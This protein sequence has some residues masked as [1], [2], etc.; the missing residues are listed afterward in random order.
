VT[1]ARAIAQ[2][3]AREA[4]AE[5]GIAA[6]EVRFMRPRADGALGRVKRRHPDR[7]YV[8]KS[9]PPDELVA[10]VRHE[11]A[12]LAQIAAGG[13]PS[14]GR[15][16]HPWDWRASV[17]ERFAQGDAKALKKLRRLLARTRTVRIYL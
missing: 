11:T 8:V 3:A 14:H 10:S 17:P 7:I 6:P 16:S 13:R 1:A 12:H 9:Q 5:L 4:A 2:R 15:H